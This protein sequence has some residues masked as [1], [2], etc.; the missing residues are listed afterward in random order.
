[1][2]TRLNP[3]ITRFALCAAT[4]ALLAACGGGGS[5][6]TSATGTPQS[7]AVSLTGTVAIGHALAGAPV[8]VTDST[9]K[10]ATATS[11]ANGIYTVAI[12]N[13][14]APLLVSAAD[15]SG[16]SS[17]TLYSV[18]ANTQTADGA[19]ATA[20]VTP[21]T[22]AVAALLTKSGSPRDL[23]AS[24]GLTA[25]TQDAVRTAVTTLDTV[26][27][28]ILVN[29]KLSA[30]S[31]DPVGGAFTPDQTGADAVIDSV[32]VTPST[33]GSGLQ[34]ASLADPNKAIQL[35]ADTTA[36]TTLDAPA[37]PANYLATLQGQL[38]QC[39]TD[40]Q[41]GA[42]SSAA[43][44]TAIDVNY[45]RGDVTS[46]GKAH[47]LFAKG[48]TLTGVKTL[49]FLPAGTL[50]AITNPAALVYFLI[51]DPDGTPNFASD[52]VQQ[53]SDGTWNI[54]GNQQKYNIYIASFLGRMQYTETAHASDGHYES[55]LDIQVPEFS[56][57]NGTQTQIYSARVQG[58]GL[59]DSG[60][61]LNAD[62][63]GSPCYLTI[64]RSPMS[65]PWFEDDNALN[66][67]PPL[68]A[69]MNTTYKWSWAPLSGDTTPFTTGGLPEYAQSSQDVSKIG[70][71]GVYTVTLYD[72]MT[73]AVVDIEKVLNIAP[74]ISAAAGT[75]VPWQALGSDVITDFLTANGSGSEQQLLND[76]DW[77]VPTPDTP[78]PNFWTSVKSVTPPY[79]VNGVP[80]STGN[81]YESDYST[82]P[83]I[84]GTK[85]VLNGLYSPLVP[86]SAA[87]SPNA[88][89]NEAGQI[90]LSWQTGG[91]YYV[92]TWQFDR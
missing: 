67:L 62:G 61:W 13:L 80:S 60:V 6:D 21:L 34:I 18:V 87:P 58:P 45:R 31:F 77:T 10:T 38:S 83:T 32:A 20:N 28:P 85:Y 55:G 79:V 90:Q 15:R 69:G 22:T 72:M 16:A 70:Q 68:E 74:N 64:P 23:A 89:G 50:P 30:S 41:G 84:Q 91:N 78:Y 43:C 7:A 47:T 14:A 81:L 5:G 2:K 57:L 1:M 56:T 54:I 52:I 11:D 29:N 35:N 19:P 86:G 75:A 37:Q 17:G 92:N 76:L 71:F 46:F 82:K 42:T 51:T 3:G 25:A 27:A 39:M 59:P 9:G 24:G 48:T 26:L 40:M 12:S 73:G 49:A 33:S 63:C 88:A 65:A 36:S 53:K 66:V 44:S 8:T 4:S